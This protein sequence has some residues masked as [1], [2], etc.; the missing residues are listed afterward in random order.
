MNWLVSYLAHSGVVG[1]YDPCLLRLLIPFGP[2][3]PRNWSLVSDMPTLQLMS[4]PK[5]KCISLGA[6]LSIVC[7]IPLNSSCSFESTG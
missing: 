5:M 4:C 7:V 2:N 6:P 3:V 1:I